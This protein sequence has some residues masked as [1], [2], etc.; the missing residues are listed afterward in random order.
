MEFLGL[1]LAFR[2]RL[3]LN[4]GPVKKA[5]I[6]VVLRL[7]PAAA[8]FRRGPCQ[9]GSRRGKRVVWHLLGSTILCNGYGVHT[10]LRGI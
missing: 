10:L 1:G 3:G 9:R 6:S 8:I 4:L 2:L 7:G 5:H